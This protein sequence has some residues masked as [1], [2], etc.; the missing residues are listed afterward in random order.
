M[1]KGKITR[2]E[3]AED[4]IFQVGKDF[5]KSLQPGI[6]AT[7]KWEA[8]LRDL[9]VV[10]LEYSAIEKQ[11]KVADGRKEFLQIKQQEETLRKKTADAI[12]AEQNALV[13]K[14]K[15]IQSSIATQQKGLSLA[16]QTIK[17]QQ[18]SIKLT[19][20][21]KLELRL[22]NR[23][24]REAAVVSSALSTEYERQSVI[25]IQLRRRYKD[26]ALTEGDTSKKAKELEA[27]IRKLDGTLKRVDANVG[28]F[29]RNVGNYGK[30]M[31]SARAAARNLAGA[32]GLVGGAFLAVRVA[33]D[34]INV[35]KD[36]EKQNATLSAI[37]QVTR[38]EMQGL[39]EDSVRLGST[40]VKTAGEVTQLQ[41]AY[42]RLG[43]SQQEIINLTEATISGSIAMNSELDQTANLVGAIVNTFDDFSSTDAPEII[44]VLSLATAKSALNFEKLQ[45]AIPITAGAANAAGIPFTKLIALLGK[46][47]DSGIDAS[48]S[49]TALRN[50]FIESAA[51]GLT[52]GQILEKIKGS[53]DKLT[54]AND[55]FGKRAAVSA[56]VLS[57][58]IDATN[59]LDE[60]LNKAAG[61]AERMANKE[62]DTLDGSLQL[63]KSAWQG[64]ILRTDDANSISTQ[65]KDTIKSLADNLEDILSTIVKVTKVFLIYLGVS[66][67]INAVTVIYTALKIGLA[68]AEL[69]FAK[70]TGIGRKAILAQVAALKAATVA[71]TALNVATKATPW[72]LIIGLLSAAAAAFIIFKNKTKEAKTELN[73]FNDEAERLNKIGIRFESALNNV[74]EGVERRNAALA[75]QENLVTSLERSLKRQGVA[76]GSVDVA[77][78]VLRNSRNKDTKAIIDQVEA[79]TVFSKAQQ[80]NIINKAAAF[81]A[82]A[83]IEENSQALIE[84]NNKK[85]ADKKEA[86]SEK[87]LKQRLKDEFNLAKQII[88]IQI[89]KDNAI[90]SNE[91][92]EN[93][94]RLSASFDLFNS[95]K[96][97]LDL[98]R[99]NA[100]TNAKGRI[101]E[102]KRIE[103]KYGSDLEKL[104]AERSKNT[105]KIFEKTTKDIIEDAKKRRADIEA[106]QEKGANDRIVVLQQQLQKELATEGINNAEK[107]QKIQEYEDAVLKI[108]KEAAINIINVQIKALEAE[109][110]NPLLNPEQRLAIEQTLSAARIALSQLE[111]TSRIS[112]INDQIEAEQKL[113]DLREELILNASN[114]IAEALDLDA[115]NIERFLTGLVD[116]F[117]SAL[118]AI[119][120]TALVVGNVFS[121]VYDNNITKLDEQIQ[122]NDDFYANVL[123]NENLSEVQRD[124]LEA[125]RDRKNAEIEKKKREQQRKKAISEKVFG[126]FQIGINTA[127]GISNALSKVVTI[128]LIPIIAALGALQLAAVLAAPIPKFFKGTQ[129]APEGWAMVDE[130]GPEIHTDKHGKIKSTGSSRGANLRYLERGDRILPNNTSEDYKRLMRA[131]I[132]TSVS[133]DNKKLTDFQ[134]KYVFNSNNDK[135]VE[136]MRLT[137]EAIKNNKTSIKFYNNNSITEDIKYYI[138]GDF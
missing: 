46:L 52:Y 60:A 112:D 118:D 74:A 50:I 6:D 4:K 67:A 93:N 36:F 69:S 8:A 7:E 138:R 38:E 32:L 57:A 43:F 134:A 44:D 26:V 92:A 2:K 103:L 68:A 100:I 102:I 79:L 64:V 108:R 136:E 14:Q 33:R 23:G 86:E 72:G 24:K 128:P 70:A 45:K 87:A 51:Q 81:K 47:S 89:D 121:S 28:Q 109:L 115:G 17:A 75:E 34:A 124:A 76:Q 54:A 135:L 27:Q 130:Q 90:L 85:A 137:R 41:I 25:L 119:G 104:E 101:A 63:L 29:Q 58:N 3:I 95:K 73:E 123:D 15:V 133:V 98:E 82:V 19:E 125:E 10:A 59:E 37:L 30:A 62:L 94:D 18:R 88:Q 55:E 96:E 113:A 12:K 49:S 56:T 116:G 71:T 80:K 122:A 111:T 117:D 129:N 42:A 61:T 126:A 39:T 48:S 131:S 120:A 107:L 65:L 78:N 114:N 91:K 132:L 106:V 11:F 9:K 99:E 127:I 66:K 16:S 84:V 22:L 31:S 97:L 40:T 21:E 53:Q 77:I 13:A 35:I 20:Q 1:A 83:K 110:N 105:T 5:A